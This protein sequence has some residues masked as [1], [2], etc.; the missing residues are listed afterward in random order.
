MVRLSTRDAARSDQT[1][2]RPIREATAV[3]PKRL[4]WWEVIVMA[5]PLA[6]A[7]WNPGTGLLSGFFVAIVVVI[8]FLAASCHLTATAYH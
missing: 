7:I 4:P 8:C 2:V 6:V 1:R 5:T 3:V